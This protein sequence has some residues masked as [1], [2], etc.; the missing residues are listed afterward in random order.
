[1]GLIASWAPPI[2]QRQFWIVQALVLTIAAAHALIET[3]GV[4][5]LEH[6][7][8]IPVSLF[9]LPVVYA[10]LAFGLRG[11][12]PTALWCATLTVPNVALWHHGADLYGE[13]WQAGLV[14]AVGIFVGQRVDRERAAR[15]DAERR[16]REQQASEDK[17]RTVFES[18]GDAILLLDTAAVI[19]DANAA[20]GE[21]LGRAPEELR[22]HPLIQVAPAELNAAVDEPSGA[23]V[24][25]PVATSGERPR[26]LVPVH[27]QLQDASGRAF[28]LLLLR[29]VSLQVERQRLLEGFAAQTLAAREEERRRIARD[30]HD[31]PIQSLVLLWRNLD[32]LEIEE[33]E[34]RATVA[35]ARATAEEVSAELRRFSR[36]LRPSVLDDLGLS[37]ALKA[38]TA[39]FEQRTGIRTR[40]AERGDLQALSD[41]SQLAVL[42]VC[43]EALHNVDRHAQATNASVRMSVTATGAELVVEDNG[44]GL[45][46]VPR[47][48]DLV[49]AGKLGLV[50]MQER[51][52]LVGGSCQA[53]GSRAGTTLR[54]SIPA[55]RDPA[56]GH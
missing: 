50:G 16:Q 17:Y 45:G 42:R 3:T 31:G 56:P 13:L 34:A 55:A 23:R 44:R 25:G 35:A 30:L 11:S 21:L 38:E 37:A 33:V 48:S 27:T 46:H 29:D 7:N 52:R 22:G 18:A 49:A 1:M 54:F 39:A 14:V 15:A 10:A 40:Y 43:Q 24:V 6:A 32:Q 8:F 12:V 47:P 4:I 28:T 51:A 20:A 2:R 41:E 53:S 19:H 5:E 26:W 9:L 36:D